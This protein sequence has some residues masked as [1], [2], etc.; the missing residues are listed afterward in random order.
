MNEKSQ[1]NPGE[2]DGISVA[3]AANLHGHQ[4]TDL[5]T[6]LR[7]APMATL[8][9]RPNSEGAQALEGALLE[10]TLEIEKHLQPRQR[11]R[12]K[13]AIT[14]LKAT[15]SAFA[16]DL[17]RWST[18]GP[19]EGFCFHSKRIDSFKDSLVQT[20][21]F[22]AVV[23]F[24]QA[25]ELIEVVNGFQ[26]KTDFDGEMINARGWATRYRAKSGLLLL[27]SEN[28][29]TSET[30]ADHY[31]EVTEAMFPIVLRAKKKSSGGLRSQGRKLKVDQSCPV[32]RRLASEVME[33]NAFLRGYSFNLEAQPSFRRIFNN[34][35]QEDFAWDQGG[36]LYANGKDNFQ[37]FP[38]DDR[39]K[40]TINGERTVELDIRSSQLTIAYG[41]AKEDLPSGDLYEIEGMPREVVKGLV[42]AMIGK[43][44]LPL[45]WPSAIAKDYLEERGRKISSDF[46]L[47]HCVEQL[48]RK[49]PLLAR[50]E[51]TGLDVYRLQYVEC[52]ILLRAMLR[53]LREHQIPSLPVHDCLIVREKERSEVLTVLKAEFFERVGIKPTVTEK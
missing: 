39:S 37:Q 27:A 23:K 32:V 2:L 29:I 34:G 50:L 36:R 42:T 15:I 16:A 19:S 45:R 24:W 1:T 17:V 18:Y 53:L 3:E 49:H 52:E 33:I 10:K 48:L 11:A 5:G 41:L 14:N 25:E 46:K 30:V 26:G 8:N 35:D 7:Q 28:G 38:S 40:I 4:S 9:W 43:G 44:S 51:A 21:Q 12:S 31:I 13:D 20:R 6:I 22:N 47:K